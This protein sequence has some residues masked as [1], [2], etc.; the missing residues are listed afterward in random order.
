MKSAVR[1]SPHSNK[2]HFAVLLLAVG[3]AVRRREGSDS[4]IAV[5]R[6]LPLGK[7]EENDGG[8]TREDLFLLLLV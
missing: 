8:R 6:L 4:V 5:R 3:A 7:A 2:H 1:P